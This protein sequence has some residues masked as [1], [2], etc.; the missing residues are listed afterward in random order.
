M[1]SNM[2]TERRRIGHLA[3]RRPISVLLLGWFAILGS[4]AGVQAQTD[5]QK[6][7]ATSALSTIFSSD[8]VDLRKFLSTVSKDTDATL[9]IT[10]DVENQLR[11]KKLSLPNARRYDVPKADIFEAYKA[12]LKAHDLVLIPIGPA[13]APLYLVQNLRSGSARTALVPVAEF[14][15]L[16][17]LD[18]YRSRTELIRTVMPLKYMDISRART[19]LNNLVSQQYG[20]INA[21]QSVNALII[22]E[23]GPVVYAI[24]KMLEQMDKKQA[25]RELLF[26]KITLEHLIAEDLEPIL[27]ELLSAAGGGS[28]F[29]GGGG[30]NRRAA[31]GG[32]N[33]APSAF[34]SP[35]PKIITEPRSNSLIIYAVQ[36]DMTKI[37]DLIKKLDQEVVREQT[38]IHI[39]RLKHA[40][41]SDIE[42]VVSDLLQGANNNNQGRR[43]GGRGQVGGNQAQVIAGN[44]ADPTDV[45]LVADGRTNSLLVHASRTQYESVLRIIQALDV[46]LPQVLIEAA[47]VELTEDFNTTF[48]IELGVVENGSADASRV[49]GVS[50]LGGRGITLGQD[51]SGLISVDTSATN[52]SGVV[53]GVFTPNDGFNLPIFLQAIKTDGKNNLLSLPSI[54]TNDNQFATISVGQEVPFATNTLSGAGNSQQSLGGYAEALITLSIS[55]HISEDQYLRLSVELTVDSFTGSGGDGLPPPRSTRTLTAVITVPNES[56][57][58][59]GGLT[60]TL[61]SVDVTKVPILGDIPL[62]GALFRRTSTQKTES[63]LYLFI[64]PKILGDPEFEELLSVTRVKEAEVEQLIGDRIDLIDPSYRNP[65]AKATKGAGKPSEEE[66]EALRARKQ[67]HI[68]RLIQ[69]LPEMPYYASPTDEAEGAASEET[70]ENEAPS[71][72]GN[73]GEG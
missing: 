59:I 23:F 1:K 9:V 51:G 68:D 18:D 17:R 42:E 21:V 16:E 27:A 6:G 11:N 26:Q 37:V 69:Q 10:A 3:F 28:A 7:E 2:G 47:I 40:L 48:G 19:E 45:H 63:T 41:A 8:E 66:A 60:Q 39:Y 38:K 46:R 62:L 70:A 22:T 24:S 32:G 56:T 65:E 44:S 31:G 29:G 34:V 71:E 5:P 55:P 72:S 30:G 35:E 13:S 14:V 43:A 36:E 67:A 12:I 58:I 61:D 20:S 73:Q 33:A 4:V 25:E 64:S 49:F 52:I 57:V 50:S 53:G 15:E 54:L